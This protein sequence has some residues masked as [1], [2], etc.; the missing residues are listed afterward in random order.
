MTEPLSP[1]EAAV[2][3]RLVDRMTD[4]EPAP[5]PSAPYPDL[6]SYND[7]THAFQQYADLDSEMTR[8]LADLVDRITIDEAAHAEAFVC[9]VFGIS[10]TEH[11]E[12]VAWTRAGAQGEPPNAVL[13]LG[14]P[15]PVD[16]RLA[17]I[18]QSPTR[19][20]ILQR[21]FSRM[22]ELRRNAGLSNG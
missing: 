22:S 16:E 10:L 5:E 20:F 7:V 1:Q 2:R 3:Q 17:R 13:K 18:I 8:A 14:H 11:D 9:E 6:L 12:M 19:L 15:V 4:T 21:L